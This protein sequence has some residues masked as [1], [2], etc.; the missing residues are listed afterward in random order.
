MATIEPRL[1]HLLNE[2]TTPE[3]PNTEV[4]NTEGLNTESITTEGLHTEGITSEGINPEVLHTEAPNA[5][6]PLQPSLPSLPTLQLLPLSGN[7]DGPLPPLHLEGLRADR[8]FGSAGRNA[9]LPGPSGGASGAPPAS[10][11]IG[12][13]TTSFGDFR[14][15]TD[16]S[17]EGKYAGSAALYPLKLLLSEV[18]MPPMPTPPA[19][20]FTSIL[21]E[22]PDFQ[23]DAPSSSFSSLSAST[24]I[25]AAIPASAPTASSSAPS[26]FTT[27]ASSS[28]ALS[29]P[30]SST[31]AVAAASNVASGSG[32][33]PSN[34]RPAIH[35][36]DDFMQLPQPSKKPK[37]HQAPL[38]PPIINGLLEPPP[39]VALFPPIE[40]SAFDDTDAGQSKLLHELSYSPPGPRLSPEPGQPVAKPRATRKRSS[41][42]R[43][44]WTEEET[45][46]LLRGVDRH[47]VG[48][49]T[50]ILDDPD[51]HFNSRSAGD[52]KDRFRTCCPEEMRVTDADQHQ[53]LAR[54]RQLQNQFRQ[55]TS[56]QKTPETATT[57]EGG[58]LS[59][60]D[61]AACTPC[62]T[63][64]PPAKK[65]RAHRMKVSD[66]AGLGIKGPFKRA[67][68]RER[69]AFSSRDD[70][71]ILQGLEAYGPSW[72]KIQRDKR[73]HLGNRQPTDLRD[74]VRNKYPYIYQR[75][76]KGVFQPKDVSTTNI[77]EPTVNTNIGHSFKIRTAAAAPPLTLTAN[78]STNRAATQEEL[79]KWLF[80]SSGPAE[81]PQQALREPDEPTPSASGGEMDIARLLLDDG[82]ATPSIT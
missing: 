58:I 21:N 36:K 18:T 4:V 32:A 41:K 44:K 25:S 29:F 66:L 43:R 48:K 16:Y 81:Q 51:F 55:L 13:Q 40:S 59:D 24:S 8:F 2:P 63:D 11:F 60:K 38:M 7:R 54:R 62:G 72:S 34:K 73:F 77:L 45:N 14:R 75:I 22:G 6:V 76:E 74:R 17:R 50:S 9:A 31:T 68:R 20:S 12:D 37:A 64:E 82:Q 53:S 56:P 49:W 27:A 15:E 19:P 47:G 26:S 46:H 65:S 5:E 71:E 10:P 35:I 78:S 28:S 52:L 39:N 70:Q 67:R 61:S 1:I 33:T 23:D 79:P 42:P 69:T 3:T 80:Q 30:S 57:T